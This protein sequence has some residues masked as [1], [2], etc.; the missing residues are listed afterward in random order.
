MSITKNNLQISEIY[1]KIFAVK[2]MEKGKKKE[3]I[4]CL[5]FEKEFFMKL[6]IE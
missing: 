5:I 6:L 1:C 2:N 4:I 3:F